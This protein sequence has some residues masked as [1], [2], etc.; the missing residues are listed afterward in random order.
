MIDP[1]GSFLRIREFYLTYLE[2]AFRI[3][4]QGLTRERRALLESPGSL[5]ADPLLEPLPRYRTVPWELA[6]LADQTEGPINHL[7]VASRKAFT[8]LTQSGLFESGEISCIS[9]RQ[10]CWREVPAP[11]PG[12]VTSGTGSGKTVVPSAGSV[13]DHEQAR[14]WTAP[15]AAT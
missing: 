13:D 7:D 9:T 10:R 8:R 3:A 14:G 12:I 2:T 5:C 15:K 11:A 4:D 6:T 1:I